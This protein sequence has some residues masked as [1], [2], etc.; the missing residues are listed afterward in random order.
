[1]RTCLVACLFA[2]SAFAAAPKTEILWDRYGVAHI[3]A[4]DR[5]S[6]FYA[7]G[8]A[9]AQA[10]GNLLLRLYGESRGRAAEYWGESHLAL[11]RWVQL[12]GVPERAKAWYEAQ[13]PEFRK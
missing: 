10:Q 13:D 2:A 8:W 1:M 12:N 4:G 5:E 6:M 7:E 11:D 3:F 9:Q